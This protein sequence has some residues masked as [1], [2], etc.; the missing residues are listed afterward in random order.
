M[1]A[2]MFRVKNNPY[3]FTV[4]KTSPTG[5]LKAKSAEG[6]ETEWS[7]LRKTLTFGFWSK[8]KITVTGSQNDKTSPI[9]KVEYYKVKAKNATDGTTPLTKAQLDNVTSWAKFSSL[10]V[11]PNEQ[12]A[13]YVKITDYAGN[14]TYI[15]TNGLIADNKSPVRSQLHLR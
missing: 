9:A 6:Q 7:E 4:D 12:C 5:S 10:E 8:K 15:S 3:K 11:R 14:Y 1:T 13:V 2:L